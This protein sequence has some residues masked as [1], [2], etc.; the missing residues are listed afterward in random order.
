MAETAPAQVSRLVQ[1]IAWMSQRDTRTPV[2][3]R[4]AAKHLKV[5]E[6]TVRGDV[7]TLLHLTDDYKE[8]LSSLRIVFTADGFLL[9]SG[10]QFQRPFRLTGDET[11]ALIVGLANARGGQSIAAK[12][13]AAFAKTPSAARAPVTMGLGPTPS[14]HV[15]AV[16]GIARQALE[17]ERK[18]EIDYCGSG[19]EPSHRLI[20]PHQIVQR[21]RWWYVIA[22]CEQVRG[23][24]RFR[25]D[26]ILDAKLLDARFA[27]RADFQ[28]V[29]K[30][31]EVFSAEASIEAAVSFSPRIARWLREK[32]PEGRE[33][34]DGRYV[35]KFR[36]ADPAWFVR[37]VLEYGA[38]AEVLQPEGLREAVR[39]VVST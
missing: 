20:W 10:G 12:L 34:R 31:E 2:S 1:L 38:E 13:G 15:D 29:T 17:T 11:L 19:A 21:Q 33:D 9:R 27:P 4:A 37:E 26:R 8:W 3:Y 14:A 24:R 39:K 28:P 30:A 35:V 6:A 22:W 16:L 36:V 32:Y 7:D 23:F 25:A 18:M 5:S